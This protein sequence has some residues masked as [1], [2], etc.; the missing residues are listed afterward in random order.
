MGR[1]GLLVLMLCVGAGAQGGGV[2][3]E[4]TFASGG[5]VIP[6]TLEVPTGGAPKAGWPVVVMVQGSGPSD[7]DE[8]LG[9]NKIFR[10]LADGLAAHG[11][12]TLRYDKRTWL[13]QRGL[14]PID[15]KVT[16]AA[17]VVDDAV[18]ALRFVS[19]AAGVDAGRVYLLGH[20]LGGSLAPRIVA[21][22]LKE[23]AG[24][25]AGI[26][27]LAAGVMPV[28]LLLPMQVEFQG[29]LHGRTRAEALDSAGQV[30]ASMREALDPATDAGKTMLLGV[31]AAY[32]REWNA[33]DTARDLHALVLPALVLHGSKD[34]QV[35][36]LDYLLMARAAT[37]VGSKSVDLPGLNHLFLPAVGDSAGEEYSTAG[38]VAP[39]VAET[40]AAWVLR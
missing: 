27:S 39:V 22:R 29:L 9:P 13:M 34:F 23:K 21:E 38:H 19:S 16:L 15:A 10:D 1:L 5:L 37:A 31:T 2:S 17:E 24:S 20:S 18:A 6:G 36:Y 28:S 33:V 8:T 40:I 35:T 26:V 7:R 32:V 4:V 14:V 25:V 3:R 11:V 12:A 30:G